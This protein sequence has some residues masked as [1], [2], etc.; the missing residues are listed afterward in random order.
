V[1]PRSLYIQQLIEVRSHCGFRWILRTVQRRGEAA[2]AEIT[3]PDQ[4]QNAFNISI[5]MP[6]ASFWPALSKRKVMRMCGSDGFD[7]ATGSRRWRTNRPVRVRLYWAG[8]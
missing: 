1:V 4:L 7:S 5:A 6:S 2:A 3:S 8:A